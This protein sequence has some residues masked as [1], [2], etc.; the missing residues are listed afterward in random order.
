LL[1]EW[2]GTRPWL[3]ALFFFAGGG[4]GVMNVYRLVAGQDAAIGWKRPGRDR[5]DGSRDGRDAGDGDEGDGRG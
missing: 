2:L 1:D 5:L 4:A 3:M